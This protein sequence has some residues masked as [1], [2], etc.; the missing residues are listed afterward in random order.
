MPKSEECEELYCLQN[1][2]IFIWKSILVVKQI[3]VYLNCIG[4]N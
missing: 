1:C 3:P 4:I 2:I